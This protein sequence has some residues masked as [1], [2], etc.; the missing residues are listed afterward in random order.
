MPSACGIGMTFFGFQQTAINAAS[1]ISMSVLALAG[2]M[3]FFWA[4]YHGGVPKKRG[5]A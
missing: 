5:S 3:L 2:G 4:K 1:F